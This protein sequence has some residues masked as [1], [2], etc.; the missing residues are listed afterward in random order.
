ME[1]CDKLEFRSSSSL[2]AYSILTIDRAVVMDWVALPLLELRI[3]AQDKKL[4]YLSG[5]TSVLKFVD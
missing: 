3:A 1:G 4:L 5:S 2:N